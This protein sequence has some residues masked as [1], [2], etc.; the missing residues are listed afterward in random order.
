MSESTYVLAQMAQ[1]KVCI[2]KFMET[3][4]LI[5]SDIVKRQYCVFNLEIHSKK[6][7]IS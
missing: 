6:I 1:I 7:M 5:T 4:I 3:T 2:F